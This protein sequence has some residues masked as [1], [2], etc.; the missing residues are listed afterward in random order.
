MARFVLCVH[1]TAMDQCDRL[2]TLTSRLGFSFIRLRHL[3]RGRAA[4]LRVQQSSNVPLGRAGWR[5]FEFG[6]RLTVFN[7]Q[8]RKCTKALTGLALF[9]TCQWTIPS[10]LQRQGGLQAKS[11]SGCEAVPD[12]VV[13]N[14]RPNSDFLKRLRVG[15]VLTRN[16][17]VSGLLL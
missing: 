1:V 4:N 16:H 17:P 5:W 12:A 15:Q 10:N 9:L 8:L 3:P 14:G 11:S 2:A 7:A 6:F 13:R